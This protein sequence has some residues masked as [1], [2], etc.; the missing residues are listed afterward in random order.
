MNKVI[1]IAGTAYSGSSML[2]MIL[3]NSSNSFA[4]GEVRGLFHPTKKYHINPECG[5]GNPKCNVWLEIQKHGKKN[6]IYRTIFN[7]YNN[8]ETII[9]SSKDP[10][11]IKKQINQ[12]H[13][14]GIK[15][16]LI[17][18]WKT[19]E[20]FALSK[21]KRNEIKFW[22]RAWINY[23]KLFFQMFK[24]CDWYT[25]KYKD[26]VKNRNSEIKK[27]CELYDLKF[28]H[29]MIFFWEKKHHILFANT[30]S[31][32]HMYDENNKAY[33]QSI[34]SLNRNEIKFNTD[35]KM[36]DSMHRSIYYNGTYNHKLPKIVYKTI[37]EKTIIKKI[38]KV[39]E[40]KDIKSSNQNNA[41]ILQDRIIMIALWYKYLIKLNRITKELLFKIKYYFM[42]KKLS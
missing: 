28:H 38:E 19:P 30:S 17:L 27:L 25:I 33:K 21:L 32:F 23:H 26:L 5:C 8:I 31:K 10:F 6:N 3:G 4:I 35:K 41:I 40:I 20:E 16:K 24:D 36:T 15:T 7:N 37:K 9:E 42:K 39:L 22:D 11:W 18:I 12:L 2:N 13:K 14:I 1:F 29:R 34:D